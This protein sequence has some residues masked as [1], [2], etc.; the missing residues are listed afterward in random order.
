[1]Q[2]IVTRYYNFYIQVRCTF[3][4]FIVCTVYFNI[5]ARLHKITTL[6][7]MPTQCFTLS[8]VNAEIGNH[9]QI[10]HLRKYTYT[11]LVLNQEPPWP[12][13]PGHP[14]S[15]G[16]GYGYCYYSEKRVLSPVSRTV[17]IRPASWRRKPSADSGAV[18]YVMPVSH[19]TYGLY[20]QASTY[21]QC[22]RSPQNPGTRG[23]FFFRAIAQMFILRML[24]T[25]WSLHG[26]ARLL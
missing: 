4:D 3:L 10:Y 21:G 12:T 23:G 26:Q 6:K 5:I 20:G 18:C 22:V 14:S 13:Q 25:I 8:R 17:V 19:R 7:Y 11:T 9:W 1:M 2:I 24:K 16:D 15:A